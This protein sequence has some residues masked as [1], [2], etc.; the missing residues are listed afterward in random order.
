M[1]TTRLFCP[2]LINQGSDCF[3]NTGMQFFYHLGA[4]NRYLFGLKDDYD[5]VPGSFLFR[6]CKEIEGMRGASGSYNLEEF[7]KFL[8]E[9]DSTTLKKMANEQHD[10]QEFILYL[11]DF[12]Y[13]IHSDYSKVL[14]TKVAPYNFCSQGDAL[15]IKNDICTLFKGY[16]Y[17]NKRCEVC[18]N[19]THKIETWGDLRLNLFFPNIPAL[20][21]E[22][23]LSLDQLLKN[24]I[25]QENELSG[26]WCTKCSKNTNQLRT[27]LLSG[28]PKILIFILRRAD[29][30]GNKILNPVTFPIE[31]F[32]FGLYT[33][34]N[35]RAMY[36][37][38]SILVHSGDA[39][40]SGHYFGFYKD[41]VGKWY[42]ANDGAYD[43]ILKS[44]IDKI[45]ITGNLS[46]TENPYVLVYEIEDE[47]S[48]MV[49][50]RTE[51]KIINER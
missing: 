23:R 4:L 22:I 42:R 47:N 10:A 39:I 6:Y 31:N 26:V 37:L 28:Y 45:A 1:V 43:N 12:F 3:L 35:I 29:A 30:N 9:Q 15:K 19:I 46:A 25:G 21:P 41:S 33:R 16:Y 44:D 20:N 5:I 49:A 7:R 14:R 48:D 36:S 18:G 34:K 2:P 13:G 24:Y 40:K 8:S 11:L 51:E 50:I 38:K 32:N 27:V 17:Y